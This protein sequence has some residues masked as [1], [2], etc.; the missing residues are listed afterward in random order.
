MRTILSP[1]WGLLLFPLS[2]HGLRRG[3]HSCAASR[4]NHGTSSASFRRSHAHANAPHAAYPDSFPV[5]AA[6]AL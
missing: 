3:L 1:L 2:T 4:L 5:A 6:F